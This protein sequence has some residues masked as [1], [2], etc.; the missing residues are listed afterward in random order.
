M[1]KRKKSI[2]Q[3]KLTQNQEQKIAS[4]FSEE[5]NYHYGVPFLLLIYD[6]AFKVADKS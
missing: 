6:T 4:S 2:L 1:E 3:G 5:E